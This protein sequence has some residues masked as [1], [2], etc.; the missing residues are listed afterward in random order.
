[1]FIH[2]YMEKF[3]DCACRNVIIIFTINT[4]LLHIHG[5]R[6]VTYTILI[7]CLLY[8]PTTS[9]PMPTPQRNSINGI[10][11]ECNEHLSM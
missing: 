2:I 9:R 6:H 3:S 1:M 10:V 11:R 7:Y 4:T 5:R 8:L